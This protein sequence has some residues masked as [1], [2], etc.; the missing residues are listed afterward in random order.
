MKLSLQVGRIPTIRHFCFSL[1]SLLLLICLPSAF[2][3]DTKGCEGVGYTNRP[4][5]E[6]SAE[7]LKKRVAGHPKDVDALI[8]LG[9]NLEEKDEFGEAYSLYEK[10]IQARPDCYL[11][12]YFAGLV[13][14]RISTR[15]ASEAEVNI[16]KAVSLNPALR[17][18]GNIQ[19]FMSRHTRRIGDALRSDAGPHSVPGQTLVSA[20]NF[21]IG[22][23]LGVFCTALLLFL[24][25]LRRS[26]ANR[27]T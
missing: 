14:D 19:G 15:S 25:R 20:N 9:I 2:A 10:A 5:S 1:A 16:A 17:E 7:N 13:T 24:A 6:Y 27:T 4:S 26:A 18:D 22:L 21:Y 3:H 12:Y 23:G 8:H 11:G